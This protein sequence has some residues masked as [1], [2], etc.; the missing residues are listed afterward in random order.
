MALQSKFSFVGNGR[1]VSPKEQHL[2]VQVA[3]KSLYMTDVPSPVMWQRSPKV[4]PSACANLH[5]SQSKQPLTLAG[6]I[7]EGLAE[8][9]YPLPLPFAGSSGTSSDRARCD[10]G[11]Q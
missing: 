6:I 8:Q 1:R 2:P 10:R 5:R 9:P 7:A 4:Q 3:S 11:E